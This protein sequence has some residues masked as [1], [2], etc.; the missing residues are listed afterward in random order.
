MKKSVV[1]KYG[2]A[3]LI[4]ASMVAVYLLSRDFSGT[5]SAAERYRMLCDAFTIPGM[6]LMLSAALI[7]LSNAGSFTGIGYSVVNLFRHLVPGGALKHE[8]YGDY[9]ERHQKKVTGYGFLLHVGGGFMAVAL[10]FYV[11]FYIVY[12]A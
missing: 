5:E 9:Y 6:V 10:I 8:T 3:M 4:G 12:K 1:I 11:L 7:A 2:I